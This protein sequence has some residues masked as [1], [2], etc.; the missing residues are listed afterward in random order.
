MNNVFSFFNLDLG[1]VT[2]QKSKFVTD[3]LQF[4]FFIQIFRLVFIFAM[5]NLY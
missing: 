1:L 3:I 4:N 2:N 5:K